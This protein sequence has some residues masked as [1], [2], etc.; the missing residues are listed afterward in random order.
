MQ[1]T[2][3][4]CGRRALVTGGT[5]S[6]AAAIGAFVLNISEL[7]PDC[8]DQLIIF[9]DGISARDQ[10]VIGEIMPTEFVRYQLPFQSRN[11]VI[12]NYFSPMLYC[13]YECFRLLEKFEEVVWSDY[14]VV[15]EKQIDEIWDH[16]RTG[17]NIVVDRKVQIRSMF[18]QKICNQEILQ[19]DLTKEALC[20]PLFS[21]SRS[22]GDYRA[23][24]QWC[25][26]KT[27]EY[28]YDINLAEQ[29]IISLM[30][31]EFQVAY[32]GFDPYVYACHPKDATGEEKILHSYGQP[33]FWS[34]LYNAEWDRLYRK[35]LRMGGS[36]YHNTKKVFVGK[37]R[38]LF[39]RIAG[40]R[41]RRDV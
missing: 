24:C 5:K 9:H 16:S 35:W 21:V 14:D 2:Q 26:D 41:A 37:V 6:D 22:I 7:C 34:G 13:K 19:Y 20:T 17:L 25:Y 36:R 10:R 29:C 32:T 30:V 3:K 40:L 15:I 12:V 1:N 8:F 28:E 23:I 33:K 27:Q 39:T 38:L 4:K 11:D 31:Q 18:F